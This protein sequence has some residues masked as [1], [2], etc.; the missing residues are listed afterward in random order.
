VNHG[1]L[2][3]VDLPNRAGREQSGRRPAVVWQDTA[4]FPLPTVVIIPF[5]SK[6]DALRF[7]GTALIQPTRPNGLTSPSVALV[8]QPGACNVRRFG[9]RVGQ[10][11][12]P[13]LATL[14]DLAKRLQKL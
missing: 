13:D 9:G 3:W 6:P 1:E 8:F 2:F 7:P 14:R 12:D 10:L 11:E 5:S 4:A